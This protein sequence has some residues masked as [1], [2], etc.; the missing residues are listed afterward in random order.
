MPKVDLDVLE[1]EREEACGDKAD[2]FDFYN[3]NWDILVQRI[4][5]LEEKSKMQ[6]K[7][8]NR[9]FGGKDVW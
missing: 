5:E 1:E 8:T 9:N 6:V 3:R 7:I 2:L 4:R